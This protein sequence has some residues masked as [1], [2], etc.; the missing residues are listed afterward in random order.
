RAERGLSPNSLRQVDHEY[1]LHSLGEFFEV[2]RGVPGVER[3]I[4]R[5][6]ERLDVTINRVRC[7]YLFDGVVGLHEDK[8]RLAAWEVE[9]VDH[10]E[11]AGGGPIVEPLNPQLDVAPLAHVP[12][13]LDLLPA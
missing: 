7:V 8:R 11:Q 2:H 6:L 1:L 3:S 5:A 12:Q 9:D 10:G 4:A 13:M